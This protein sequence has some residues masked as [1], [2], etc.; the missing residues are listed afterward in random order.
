MKNK[1]SKCKCPKCKYSEEHHIGVPCS[2]FKCPHHKN[3]LVREQEQKLWKQY[4]EEN[5][6]LPAGVVAAGIIASGLALYKTLLNRGSKKKSA[7]AAR[8]SFLQRSLSECKN[9]SDPDACVQKLGE[10]IKSMQLR[11]T[12]FLE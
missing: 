1:M 3:S 7:I 8:I 9:T 4:I 10:E 2:K 11:Y 6:L 12:K 5:K